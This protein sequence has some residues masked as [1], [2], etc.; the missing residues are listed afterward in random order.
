MRSLGDSHG[1][2]R[3]TL[4]SLGFRSAV[5]TGGVRRGGFEVVF[6]Q[7]AA[8]GCFPHQRAVSASTQD[9]LVWLRKLVA[10]MKASHVFV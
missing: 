2:D 9:L 8:R 3:R 4:E 5:P 6:K 1:T 7:G 10:M